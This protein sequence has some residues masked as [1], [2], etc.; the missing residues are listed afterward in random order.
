[1][2]EIMNQGEVSMKK[3]LFH[4]AIFVSAVLLTGCSASL[5]SVK[6]SDPALQSN[7]QGKKI[8]ASAAYMQFDDRTGKMEYDKSAKWLE[9]NIDLWMYEKKQGVKIVQIDESSILGPN[10]PLL[11]FY[12]YINE[13]GKNDFKFQAE[14]IKA[15]LEQN[16]IDCLLLLTGGTVEPASDEVNYFKF[17]EFGV[18]MASAITTRT[19]TVASDSKF[20]K[21][22]QSIQRGMVFYTCGGEKPLFIGGVEGPKDQLPLQKAIYLLADTALN[23]TTP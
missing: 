9:G 7:F 3:S 22:G 6:S 13:T 17:A 1:M 14:Q 5:K 21:S 12:P 8:G 2:I 4:I 11:G 20:T 18:R 23:K 16:G 15:A 10:R 19:S